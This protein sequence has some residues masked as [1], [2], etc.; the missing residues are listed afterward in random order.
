MGWSYGA[1]AILQALKATPQRPASPSP[2]FTSE[3]KYRFKAGIT[4]YPRCVTV[5]TTLYAPVLIFWGDKD[6]H[7][8]TTGCDN[9][10]KENRAGGEPYSITVYPGATNFF[11]YGET[12][13]D[14]RNNRSVPDP[15]ATQ[16]AIERVKAFLLEKL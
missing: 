15:S 10:P 4:Y 8:T 1:R 11:D 2:F 14:S 3:P 13:R 12:W 5:V 7:F 16:D 9:F 6:K